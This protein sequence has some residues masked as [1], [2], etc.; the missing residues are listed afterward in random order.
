MNRL[1]RLGIRHGWR[2]GILEGKR[3]WMVIGAVAVGARAMQQLAGR[4][5]VVVYSERLETGD[6]LLI[7]NLRE[8]RSGQRAD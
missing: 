3:S 1:I 8:D 4:K 2:R 5:E 6:A 7:S